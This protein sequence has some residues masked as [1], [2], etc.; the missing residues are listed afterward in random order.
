MT[1]YSAP[2]ETTG[3][4]SQSRSILCSPQLQGLLRFWFT[5]PGLFW[6]SLWAPPGMLLMAAN[7]ALQARGAA[8]AT[9]EQRLFP[10]ACKRWFG[11][12][13]PGSYGWDAPRLAHPRALVPA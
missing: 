6:V 1:R 13:Y 7:A 10:V 9:Q 5:R 8:G 4:R 2:A 12:G 11:C 3:S